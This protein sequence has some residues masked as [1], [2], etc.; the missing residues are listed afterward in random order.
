LLDKGHILE[1][2][3]N[4]YAVQR[5]YQPRTIRSHLASLCHLYDFWMLTDTLPDHLKRK[6][7]A[8]KQSVKRWMTSYRKKCKPK[9]RRKT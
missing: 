1:A 3:L 8:M 6:V 5:Q 2:F 9:A 4:G 7:T